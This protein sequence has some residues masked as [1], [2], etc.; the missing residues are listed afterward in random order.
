MISKLLI[1]SASQLP[2]L[3]HPTGYQ[4]PTTLVHVPK[5]MNQGGK[6]G[7]KSYFTQRITHFSDLSVLLA[8]QCSKLKSASKM[9]LTEP[10]IHESNIRSLD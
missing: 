9:V 10:V 2:V 6:C 5:S 1:T 4:G 8:C 3:A 7:P